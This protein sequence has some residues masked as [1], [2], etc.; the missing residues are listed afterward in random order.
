MQS[1]AA[2]APAGQV[3]KE[4]LYAFCVLYRLLHCSMPMTVLLPATASLLLVTNQRILG[5]IW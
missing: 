1:V 3:D 2:A 5:L 4:L